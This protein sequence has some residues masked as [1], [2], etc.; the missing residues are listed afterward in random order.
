MNFA[1]RMKNMNKNR[2]IEV[3]VH[4]GMFIEISR[5]KRNIDGML[6]P[7]LRSADVKSM[8]VVCKLLAHKMP[9]AAKYMR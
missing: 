2:N 4:L 1:S 9:P 5:W 3:F 8:Y 6:S 7:I